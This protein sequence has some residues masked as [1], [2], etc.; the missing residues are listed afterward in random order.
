M[1]KFEDGELLNLL[2]VSMAKDIETQCISYALKRQVQNVI[3][4]SGQTRTVAMI[5]L[6]PEHVLDALA[7]E[8]RTMYY[9]QDMPLEQKRAIVK[10]T[11]KWYSKAGTPS[12]VEELIQVVL[13]KERLRNGLTTGKGHILR[14]HS[15]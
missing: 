2:P 7:V 11:M 12:A 10:S 1:I 5:D 15:I 9:S 3:Y 4:F 14:E 6:L 13:E 8:M